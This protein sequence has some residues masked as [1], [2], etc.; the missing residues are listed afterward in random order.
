MELD[1]DQ[2]NP[3]MVVPLLT[4]LVFE[5][6]LK[7]LH[8]TV[9]F[10]KLPDETLGGRSACSVQFVY[11]TRCN[12]RSKISMRFNRLLQIGVITE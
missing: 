2:P 6:F 11:D 3:Q 5:Y 4:D 9:T 7:V 10:I 1:I 8:S 12:P